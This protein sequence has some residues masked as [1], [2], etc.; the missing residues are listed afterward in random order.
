MLEMIITVGSMSFIIGACVMLIYILLAVGPELQSTLS[1]QRVTPFPC[2]ALARLLY[3][4]P[5]SL[6]RE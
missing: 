1:I 6:Y 2:A 5:H 3:F 4:N